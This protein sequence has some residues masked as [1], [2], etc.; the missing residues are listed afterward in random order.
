MDKI[1]V[2]MIQ[3]NLHAIYYGA[4]MAKHDPH[5]LREPEIGL[6]GYFYFYARYNDTRLMTVPIVSGFEI[7]K[8]WDKERR[9]AENMSRIFLG[10]P[11]VCDTIEEVS[12]GVDLVFI[13]DCNGDGSDHLRLATP[14]LKKG[15]P[16][17]V[18]KPFAY[19]IKDALA[20]VRLAKRHGTPVMSLSIL[21]EVPHASRFRRRFDEL[22]DVTF[23]IIH[24]GGGNAAGQIHAIS[25]AQHLFGDGVESVECMGGQEFPYHAYLSY[26]SKN[27]RP[28]RGVVLGL[29][30]GGGPHCAFYASVFSLEG[31]IHSP[32]IGDFEFPWG[33]ASILRKVKRMVQTGRPQ[34]LYDE[35]I[36]NIAILS[37]LR[38]AHKT[39]RPVTLREVWHKS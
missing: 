38:I 17:F 24:G 20:I 34:A 32:A 30:G 25:L 13:A 12:D 18:D 1:R 11:Q 29:Y 23:A 14:G 31:A 4:L 10:K 22:G 8:L 9:L 6:G 15:V 21:R 37:A 19:E 2:G 33:S 5:I 39:G 36:E 7:I 27:R 26:G 35:M 3:C 16:T 28:T